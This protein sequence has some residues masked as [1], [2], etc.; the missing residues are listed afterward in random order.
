[1]SAQVDQI[2]IYPVKSVGG[3]SLSQSWADKEGL[4]FDRRFMLAL[5]DGGMVTARKFPRLV[6]VRS[7]LMPDGV[8]FQ[9]EGEE[10]LRIRYADFKMQEIATTV[11][12]DTFTAYTTTDEAND[13]FSRVIDRQVELI[14]TGEHSQRYRESVGNTVGFADG[15]PL[16]IISQGSLDELNRRSP[17]Q[18]VM[19]QF[20]ANIV[21]SGT[22][23]FAE[24]GWKRIRIGTAEFELVKPCERCIL[25]TVEPEHGQLRASQEPLKTLVQFR[26]GA[27]G[28]VFFGQNMV[29]RTAGMIQTDDVVE[30]L[31]YKEKE[32]YPD[33]QP[34]WQTLT[35]V[36]KEE[37]ARDFVTFWLEP[38]QGQI[39]T[40]Q[41]GQHLPIALTI[42]GETINRHYT[43]SSSPS[44]PGRLAISVKRVSDGQVSNWL[45]DHFQIGDILQAQAPNGQFHLQSDSSHYPLLLLSAGSGVTPMLSMLRY[46]ADHQ[47][48]RDVVFYHQCRSVDDIPCREELEHLNHQHSGLKVIIS[49][50]QPPQEWF[51]LK[52]RFSLSHLRQVQ[53]V[54]RRQVFVCG[55][56]GF[57][58]KAKN[59]LMKAGLPAHYYHQEAF[60]AQ[61]I[62]ER[63]HLNVTLTINGE[64]VAG[65]NQQTL[66]EQAEEQGIAISNSCRAG[67]CGAC[68]VKVTQGR[69]SQPDVPALEDKDR[70]AGMVLACCCVPDTDLEISY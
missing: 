30:V 43:L 9:V 15:Y 56:D 35:C 36:E 23:P 46:L 59:L 58:K 26:R 52:G 50:T 2:H 28:G 13:W 51:G 29:V 60:G 25:T 27:S 7:A 53:D 40:Y 67:L 49:L 42:N 45:L 66:L 57:M 8:L 61:K 5:A 4:A 32:Q 68:R 22:E 55:P 31:E 11:W 21:V 17:E 33:E 16:L 38:Q 37:I 18:H 12:R 39:L 14:F 54:E 34:Q 65:N 69:V 3:I 47:Q 24:D 10:P 63:P 1:M 62:A 20:R 44:R 41:P 70:Q 48:M 64:K 6:T 19:Q